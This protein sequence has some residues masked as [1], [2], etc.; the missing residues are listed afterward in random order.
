MIF[1]V[2]DGM[3]MY[4]VMSLAIAEPGSALLVRKPCLQAQ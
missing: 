1:F 2:S 3:Y 4:V